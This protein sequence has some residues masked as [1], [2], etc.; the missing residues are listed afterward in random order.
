MSNLTVTASGVTSAKGTP[1]EQLWQAKPFNHDHFLLL[2]P[3]A[4]GWLKDNPTSSAWAL[5]LNKGLEEG[6]E[7][8]FDEEYVAYNY[9]TEYLQA[10][11][12]ALETAAKTS[13][14]YF[15]HLVFFFNQFVLGE[16]NST[17]LEKKY[18]LY[19]PAM[20]FTN[21]RSDFDNNVRAVVGE[22]PSIRPF[23][24]ADFLRLNPSVAKF[25]ADK[26]AE[27]VTIDVWRYWVYQGYRETYANSNVP[28]QA[29]FDEEYYLKRFPSVA[30]WKTQ[31][32]NQF[33]A[34]QWH[35]QYG[36][37]D[38]NRN[39][40]YDPKMGWEMLVSS[41][42]TR[43]VKINSRPFLAPPPQ[44]QI[45]DLGVSSREMETA[46]KAD[47]KDLKGDGKGMSTGVKVA[48]GVAG[49]AV[50]AGVVYAATRGKK[51]KAKGLDGL[52]KRGKDG[53]F[54][55]KGSKKKA[56]AKGSTGTG[57]SFA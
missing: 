7:G 19:D 8:F 51:G 31:N 50:V 1:V 40:P 2:N 15:Q 32:N 18:R 54:L 30:A 36:L 57:F 55:K 56:K 23:S 20:K 35:L 49:A 46:D 39:P 41:T 14:P 44:E 42:G 21:T 43:S 3:G 6:L 37:T 16:A 5:W 26:K 28:R 9:P 34:Y 52:P 53:K 24:E 47:T 48:I 4:A 12:Q 27:G 17:R 29:F 13:T 22:R 11:E 33:T 25:V 38:P 45:T 10:Y